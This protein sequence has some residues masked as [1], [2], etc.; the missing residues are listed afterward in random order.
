[1]L[2]AHAAHV[3]GHGDQRRGDYRRHLGALLRRHHPADAR[4]GHETLGPSYAFHD[5]PNA[6][7]VEPLN[8]YVPEYAHMSRRRRLLRRGPA[9]GTAPPPD[10]AKTLVRAWT[11]RPLAG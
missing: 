1:M 11:M 10:G 3:T 7:T 8:L 9:H 6:S 5:Q 2:Y 4:H